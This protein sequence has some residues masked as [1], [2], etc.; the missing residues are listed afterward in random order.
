MK[1]LN[2]I[3]ATVYNELQERKIHPAGTFDKGGRFYL[4]NSDLVNVRTPS[5]TWPYS[6]MVAGRTK[7]YVRKVAEKYG[8]DSIEALRAAV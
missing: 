8:C 5:R 6:Q 7:K 4:N 2:E 1:N 3:I